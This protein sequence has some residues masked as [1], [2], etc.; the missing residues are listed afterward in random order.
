MILCRRLLARRTIIAGSRAVYNMFSFRASIFIPDPSQLTG[1]SHT[2]LL[3]D[4]TLPHSTATLTTT[5]AVQ[6]TSPYSADQ[7]SQK[8]SWPFFFFSFFSGSSS[9]QGSAYRLALTE[10]VTPPTIY[11]S[12]HDSAAYEDA[13]QQKY[14]SKHHGAHAQGHWPPFVHPCRVVCSSLVNTQ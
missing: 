11:Y 9:L 5:R 13:R 10:P 2:R 1:T 6:S 7:G 8:L 3:F 4:P 14:R 12:S